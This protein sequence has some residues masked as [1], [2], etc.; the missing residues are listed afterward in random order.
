MFLSM[1]LFVICSCGTK[2]YIEIDSPIKQRSDLQNHMHVTCPVCR[3]TYEYTNSDVCAETYP[4]DE[5]TGAFIGGVI[6][7]FSPL[8]LGTF[9]GAGVGSIIA[10]GLK[11]FD[12][13]AVN[14]FNES[15]G[16]D[17]KSKKIEGSGVQ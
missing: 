4:Y 10:S 11:K 17:S 12:D 1:R 7:L 15:A 8:L 3:N 14:V 16:I 6:G 13:I 2:I 9:I 5:K